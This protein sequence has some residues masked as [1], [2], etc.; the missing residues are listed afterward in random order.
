MIVAYIM[1][2]IS[3]ILM[4]TAFVVLRFTIGF[5]IGEEFREIALM[6]AMGVP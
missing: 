1:M 4:I 3:I 5:T 2:M 6:K